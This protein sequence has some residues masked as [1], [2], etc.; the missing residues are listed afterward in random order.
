MAYRVN[1]VFWL[2][3]EADRVEGI[4]LMNEYWGATWTAESLRLAMQGKGLEYSTA[5]MEVIA[6]ELVKRKV[7][8][9]V[10]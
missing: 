2:K 1:P 4:V 3:T 5:Q 8:E 6:A 7:F 9:E 10:E